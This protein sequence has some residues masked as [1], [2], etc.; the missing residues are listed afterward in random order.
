M[1][2]SMIYFLILKMTAMI[3]TGAAAVCRGIYLFQVEDWPEI[4][5]ATGKAIQMGTEVMSMYR[6][7]IM[8]SASAAGRTARYATAVLVSIL[9]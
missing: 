9:Q 2:F 7:L 3:L 1:Y 5:Q 8:I 6:E 4:K